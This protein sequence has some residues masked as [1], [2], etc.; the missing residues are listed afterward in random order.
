[1]H[2]TRQ[3]ILFGFIMCTVV[4]LI[5]AGLF[6]VLKP[7][8]DKNEQIYNKKAV[9]A[10]VAEKLDVDFNKITG[11][12]VEEIFKDQI[13]QVAVDTNGDILSTEDIQSAGYQ[14]GN[15]ESIDMAKEVKKAA[16]DRIL[17]VFIYTSTA[18]KKY[19]VLST[20]GKGLWDE[21]WGNIAFEDDLN[22]IAGVS[23][24]HTA[25]TPGLGAEIKDNK[26]WS[27]QFT[28]KKI[29]GPDGKFKSVYVRKG[30]AKDEVYEVDGISGATITADGVTDMLEIGLKLYEPYL[31]TVRG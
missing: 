8:H 12:Q 28:G 14:N 23:F 24:D 22:T 18:G 21:I 29:Y 9:L 4:A 6:N 20:R 30:G 1:M 10:A 17:P 25:E 26:A 3:V 2:S 31:K 11:E 7:I 16:D 15:A 19:Y 5:L 13:K 27:K